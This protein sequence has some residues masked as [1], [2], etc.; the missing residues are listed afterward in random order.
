MIKNLVDGVGRTSIDTTPSFSRL[1][2]VVPTYIAEISP[3]E[4]RGTLLVFEQLSIVIGIIVAFWITYGTRFIDNN[5]SWR[6]PFLIQIIPGLVLGLGA[7]F[8]P[9]SPRWLANKGRDDEALKTLGKLRQLPV[10]DARVEKEW[11]DI[12]AE[13]RYQAQQFAEAHSGSVQ[14]G[15]G[16]KIKLEFASWGDCFKGRSWRRTAFGS[17]IT[18]FQ[19]VCLSPLSK[20]KGWMNLT[21]IISSSVSTTSSTTLLL[22][23]SKWPESNLVWVQQH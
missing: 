21:L 22:F 5:L 2:A 11:L 18:T 6:L 14:R 23:S 8:L 20:A 16:S 13:S 17:G 4:V 1:S 3:A 15:L 7:I 12:L 10:T 19:Q 9:F